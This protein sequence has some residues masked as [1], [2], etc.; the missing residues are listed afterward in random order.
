MTECIELKSKTLYWLDQNTFCLAFDGGIDE[1]G[2]EYSYL[3]EYH[4]D[5]NE[6]V[7]EMWFED[8]VVF[9]NFSNEQMEYIKQIMIGAKNEK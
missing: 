7:F 3:V 5:K 2:D 8:M 6:F 9:A 1:D 4:K